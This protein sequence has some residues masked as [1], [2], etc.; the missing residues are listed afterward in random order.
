MASSARDIIALDPETGADQALNVPWSS[1]LNLRT[2][3]SRARPCGYWLA[4]SATTAVERLRL[5]GVQVLRVAESGTVLADAFQKPLRESAAAPDTTAPIALVRSTLDAPAGS[6]YVPLNQ[7][8]ANLAVAALEAD[9]PGSYFGRR[10]IDG[11]AD[12]ARVMTT[13]SLIFDDLE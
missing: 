10:L 6:F 9:I 13:P 1:A 3:Q 5:L 12:T 8:M 2:V 11:L 4:P 7:P